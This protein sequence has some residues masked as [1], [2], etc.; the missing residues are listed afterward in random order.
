MRT[1]IL[2]AAALALSGCDTNSGLHNRIVW[3]AEGCAFS[4]R[5]G[6]GGNSFLQRMTDA[7]K[8]DCKRTNAEGR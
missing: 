5:D 7:D 6:V 3:D 8:P 2:L 1:V 4:V